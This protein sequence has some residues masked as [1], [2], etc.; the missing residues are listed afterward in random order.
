[1]ERCSRGL[2]IPDFTLGDFNVT[3]D[4]INRMP[5][6]L[7]NK[8]VIAALRDVQHEWNMRDTWHWANPT[9]NVFMYRAQTQNERI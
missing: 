3:K 4:T 6:K 7:D 9:E 2:P 5:P 1:M 8:A